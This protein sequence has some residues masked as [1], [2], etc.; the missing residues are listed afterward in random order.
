MNKDHWWHLAKRFIIGIL[1]LIG[2]YSLSR[3]QPIS[4]LL[5]RLDGFFNTPSMRSSITQAQIK[6]GQDYWSPKGL[7]KMAPKA[8]GLWRVSDNQQDWSDGPEL[9]A[10][11]YNAAEMDV[12]EISPG[13]YKLDKLVIN[14]PILIKGTGP[15][16]KDVVIEI[17]QKSEIDLFRAKIKKVEFQ[18]LTI[19]A[20]GQTF[21][22][23]AFL[24]IKDA[25]VGLYKTSFLSS[26][27][28]F[29]A[30][31]SRNSKLVGRE[32]EFSS[33]DQFDTLFLEGK[34]Q[35]DLDN[36]HFKDHKVAVGTHVNNFEGN[37]SISNSD[38]VNSRAHGLMIYGGN[39][40]LENVEFHHGQGGVYLGNKAKATLTSIIFDGL[41]INGMEISDGASAQLN[42]VSITAE[43]TAILALGA[44]STISG[45]EVTLLGGQR[46]LH[47]RQGA[48]GTLS[49]STLQAA[50]ISGI[51][52][53]R[54]STLTLEETN[55]E[56]TTGNC[57]EAK[58]SVATLRTV[59]MAGC[60][61]GLNLNQN[62]LIKH[63]QL[64]FKNNK[65]KIHNNF[66]SSKVQE[67]P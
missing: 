23:D 31:L 51:T 46:G 2:L 41:T 27:H 30:S 24:T 1:A 58:D 33:G 49:Q 20:V 52:L 65:E 9:A 4:D 35:L 38:I 10:I 28:Q 5:A 15:R 39:L 26:G 11:L 13:T 66:N 56:L 54:Q 59:T 67:L 44:G 17:S 3:L 21:Y 29:F 60:L 34:S 40:K 42:D 14:H 48:V 62:C 43:H 16:P 37:I 63:K 18:G 57:I 32:C 47:L 6:R 25:E 53:E 8:P 7:R 12:V 22:N 55:F 50:T 36:C 45:Q 19:K 61:F 64:T